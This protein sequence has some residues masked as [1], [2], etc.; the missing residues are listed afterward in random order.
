MII[1]IVLILIFDIK[2]RNKSSING[3]PIENKQSHRYGDNKH[4]GYNHGYKSRASYEK[5]DPTQ[6]K[7]LVAKTLLYEGRS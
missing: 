7:I 3:K 4:K 5:I 6:T 2:D 1:S